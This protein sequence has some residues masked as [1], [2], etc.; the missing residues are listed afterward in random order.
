VAVPQHVWR[1]LDLT[2]HTHYLSELL[3]QTVE[4]EMTEEALLLRQHDAARA[5][6]KR[7]VE[8][9]DAD[10]DRIIRSLHQSQCVV[11]GK[12]RQELPAIFAE[13]G[14]FYGVQERLV[15]PVRAAFEDGPLA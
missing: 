3:R 6:I 8:M 15:E 12:L 2:T 10:A 1:H 14:A 13:G 9:P 11:S 7:W 5:A 4:H